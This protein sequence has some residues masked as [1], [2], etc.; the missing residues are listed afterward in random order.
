MTHLVAAPDQGAACHIQETHTFCHLSP[1][2]KLRRFNVA[3]DLHVALR[4]AHV[5]TESDD[6]NVNL[7]QLCKMVITTGIRERGG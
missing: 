4:R 2:I 7:A 3:V 1:V 5:L 6:V